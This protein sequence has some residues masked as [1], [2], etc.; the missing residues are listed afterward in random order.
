[1]APEAGGSTH[2]G[3][4]LDLR[5]VIDAIPALV[6]CAFPGGTLEFVNQTLREFTGCP[7]DQLTAS[8]WHT[9]I[10]PDDLSD[11][12]EQWN[13]ARSAG[14]PLEIEVRIRRADGE[15][16]WFSVKTVPHRGES[17]QI[18]RWYGTGC[19]IDDRKKAE[20]RSRKNEAE[21]RTII[22]TIPAFVGT[23][24]PDGS[25]DF[26]S[27]SW[28]DYTGLT[29]EQWL[30]WGWTTVTH[31]DDLDNAVTKWRAAMAARRPL[32][33][34]QRCRHADGK[35]RWFLGRNVPLLDEQGN[36]VKWYG[37]LHDIDDLKRTQEELRRSEALLSEAQRL[38]R[39]GSWVYY[40]SE[41]PEYW[42]PESF[43][44]IGRDPAKGP[45]KDLAEFL[46]YVHPDDRDFLRLEVDEIISKSLPFDHRYRIVRSDGQIRVVREL[47]RPIF[48]NGI[49]TRF[50][51]AWMDITEQEQ[52]IEDLRRNEFYLAE[53][54][55][56]AHMGSWAF[57]P[58]GFYT[59][60]SREL[61]EIY[62]NDPA[63]GPPSLEQ[64]LA[65]VNPQDR[66]FMAQKIQQMVAESLGCDLKKRIV[67]PTGDIRYIRCV[68]VPII[69][70]GKLKSIVGTAIDI[71]EQ[72]LLTQELRRRECYLAEAQRLSH[73]GSFGWKI[74]TGEII[75]SEET[76]RIFECDNSLKP[77]LDLVFQRI[78]PDDAPLVK[79]TLDRALQDGKDFD[80]EHRLQMPDG[81]IKHVHVVAHASNDATGQLEFIGAVMDITA[82]KEAENKIRLIIDTVPGLLWT[83]GPD[84]A[85]DFIGKRWLEYTGMTME[86]ALGPGWRPAFHPDDIERVLAAWF[87]AV[88]E[89]KP[90]DTESRMR[91]FDGEYR[92]FLNRAFPL[93][94]RSGQALGWY[95]NEI[96]IHERKQAEEALRVSE[97]QWRNVFENN[98][99]MYFMVD[100]AGVVL[101]VNPHGAEQLGYRIQDLVGQPVLKVFSDPDQEAA[102]G[103]IDQ[104]LKQFGQSMSWELRKVR[105]DG[106][107]LWVR[108]TARAVFRKNEP[109]VLI[110]CEDIT[111][112]KLAEDKIHE[113]EIELR[114]M[115]DLTPQHVHVLTADASLVFTNEVA[116]KFHGDTLEDWNHRPLSEWQVDELPI[117][118][119]HPDDR[120]R[121]LAEL[122]AALSCGSQHETE[123]RLLRNDGKYIWFLFRYNALRDEHGHVLRWYVAG[124]DIEDRKRA[125]ERLQQENVA[126]REE[127]DKAS[128]FEEIVGTSPC[129]QAVLSRVSKVAPTDSTVLITGETGTGK[130][131]VARAIHRRSH[132]S[133]GA[134]V[135]VNCAAIPRDLIASELFGHEK[136]AFTGAMQ[137]RLGRFEL[138]SGGTI[139]LDEVGELPAET[140]VALLRVLQEH[141]FE[142][143][144]GTKSIQTDVRVIAA[145]NRDLNAAISSGAFRSDLFYR[146]NVFP[147]EIPALRD[148]KEDIVLLVEYFL[149]RFARKTG[150]NFEGVSKKTL[151]LLQSYPW[152][153]N[154]RELQNVIER[155][156]IVCESESFSVDDSWISRPPL[157]VTLA[158]PLD[159]AEKLAAQEKQMIESALKECG[160][161]I[162]GP[163]GAAAK[164]GIPRSTLES[165]IRSLKINKNR[166][167]TASET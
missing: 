62:G 67:R 70:K 27:Q 129:L 139:F 57:D 16:R 6:F 115:L 136:G 13:A 121:V 29:R 79:A 123:A 158:S 118:L 40:A 102:R 47:G 108:E 30:D 28:L 137:R 31:P 10:H 93:L 94:D 41:T 68:G 45:P 48:E 85:V 64:Y 76:F 78:H 1:M 8:G 122:K 69:D 36:V 4:P 33:N 142:R 83:A 3:T 37:T 125:E 80:I 52:R 46:P 134:F 117:S 164:L 22:E 146:L 138:A 35:Y 86:Q 14:N 75:W 151:D 65:M 92:W 61:F 141:E 148:R 24:L 127:I 160:G 140:Q 63:I 144:G 166:F 39:V 126:L 53:G 95:G 149:D 2:L 12:L 25:V 74:S 23:A 100:A 42:S 90:L 159:L 154:I 54:Q 163:S 19:D 106:S 114:Q 66:E 7:P 133:S 111:E 152:P 59:H 34:E 128:M 77:S 132:R 162:F 20:D 116:H 135:S 157:S 84:G 60:W 18:T 17:A 109:V 88:A 153:G 104:C 21:L 98:P 26:V 43:E 105:K 73:T 119:F 143:V 32:E 99:T 81:A 91:R 5:T 49:V 38:T 71:T 55:R 107:L 167:R 58:G 72:E 150:K 147:I 161:R 82:T 165:K 11:F 101:A 51:G 112:R 120:E 15:Y 124:T 97:E 155:S 131:L 9:V 130:E 113:Q 56:L 89:K 103:Y 145:T 156:V 110:A 44:I 87:K 50:I 96:D